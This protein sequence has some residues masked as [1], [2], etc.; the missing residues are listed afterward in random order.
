MFQVVPFETCKSDIYIY[1]LRLENMYRINKAKK[2]EEIWDW[3]TKSRNKIKFLFLLSFYLNFFIFLSEIA[4]GTISSCPLQKGDGQKYS[5]KY[6][7]TNTG[8][9][10]DRYPALTV[11]IKT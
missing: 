1:I 3:K 9:H 6:L 4:V 2:L 11:F 7:I 5:S 10:M 8:I